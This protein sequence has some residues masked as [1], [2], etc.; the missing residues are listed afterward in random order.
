M[1]LETHLSGPLT[2]LM[3]LN[4]YCQLRCRYCSSLPFNGS[5]LDT[6]RTLS[7]IKELVDYPV[8]SLVFS[9]GE[10]FLHPN[11]LD[12]IEV[13]G[14]SKIHLSINTNGLKLLD[15][16]IFQGLKIL[17]NNGSNFILN[18]SLDSPMVED[19]DSARGRGKEVKE[20]IKI[21]LSEGFDVCINSTIHSKNFNTALSLLDEFKN[22]K[23]YRFFPVIPTHSSLSRGEDLSMDEEDANYFWEKAL[24]LKKKLGKNKIMLPFRSNNELGIMECKQKNCFCGFTSCF[25]DSN[26]DVYPCDWSKVEENKLGNI[27]EKTLRSV[28]N[29]SRA[30]EIRARGK[31]SSL[32]EASPSTIPNKGDLPIRYKSS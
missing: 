27:S 26:F 22:V 13:V 23:Q 30:N 6:E 29:S 11:I 5:S 2:V 18:I 12:F 17:R 14:V 4:S 1:S 31:S 21:A 8:W 25:I 19:N 24:N 7:L 20:A 28:W 16:K 3:D 9:G 32:C 15:N 10:P